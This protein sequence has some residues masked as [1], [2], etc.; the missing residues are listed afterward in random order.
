LSFG[1]GGSQEER[2][3]NRKEEEGNEAQADER[4]LKLVAGLAAMEIAWMEFFF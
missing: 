2:L 4:K 1:S 3:V